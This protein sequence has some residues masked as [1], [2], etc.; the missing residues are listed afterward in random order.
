MEKWV[1]FLTDFRKLNSLLK[2]KPVYI[3]IIEE[4]IEEIGYFKYTTTIHLKM[5]NMN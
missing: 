3:E 5:D 2:K 4:I 1:I